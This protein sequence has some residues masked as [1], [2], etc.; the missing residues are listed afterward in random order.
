M[1]EFSTDV[2]VHQVALLQR[3]PILADPQWSLREP[4][5]G[6]VSGYAQPR[7]SDHLEL[8]QISPGASPPFFKGED[9]RGAGVSGGAGAD[10]RLLGAARPGLDAV[11]VHE[12]LQDPWPVDRPDAAGTAPD[13]AVNGRQERPYSGCLA[14]LSAAVVAV[15]ADADLLVV[16]H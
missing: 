16:R 12:V 2:E 15:D 1:G 11:A 3:A 14:A 6:P 8:A 7:A 10:G 13:N 5:C 4:I 9:R